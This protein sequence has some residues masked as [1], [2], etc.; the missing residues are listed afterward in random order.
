MRLGSRPLSTDELA[1]TMSVN[2]LSQPS[3]GYVIPRP[4]SSTHV[5]DSSLAA[6]PSSDCA[7]RCV[8]KL[9]VCFFFFSSRVS[10]SLSA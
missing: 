4:G 9:C 2:Y 1:G 7:A 8:Q 6:P 5:A 10:S 3:R